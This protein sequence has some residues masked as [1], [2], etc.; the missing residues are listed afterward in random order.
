MEPSSVKFAKVKVSDRNCRGDPNCPTKLSNGGK[1]K[2]FL[3]IP[4][5]IRT[6]NKVGR[7]FWHPSFSSHSCTQAISDPRIFAVERFASLCT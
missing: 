6:I 1:C 3:D 4:T 5:A 7:L 2:V